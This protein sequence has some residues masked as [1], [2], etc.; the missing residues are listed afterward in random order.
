MKRTP[1]GIAAARPERLH[2]IQIPLAL[3]RLVPLTEAETTA[4]GDNASGNAI[5]YHGG[6]ILKSPRVKP[7]FWGSAW[8][9]PRLHPGPSAGD[10]LWAMKSLFMGP[11]MSGLNQYNGIGKGSMLSEIFVSMTQDPPNPFTQDDIE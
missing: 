2:H 11:Y 1:P 3:Q 4:A 7:I 9:H 5:V 6:R 10:V 8:F